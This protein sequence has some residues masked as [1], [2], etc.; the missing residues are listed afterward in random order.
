MPWSGRLAN[1]HVTDGTIL[2]VSLSVSDES[3]NQYVAPPGGPLSPSL[4]HAARLSLNQ[5][6]VP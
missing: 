4:C 2:L 6:P 1:P 3:Q 5:A